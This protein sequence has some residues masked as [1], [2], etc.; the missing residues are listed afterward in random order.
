MYLVLRPPWGGHASATLD[1][2]VVATATPDAPAKK[3]PNKQQR[4][5]RP[6]GT[7]ASPDDP[8]D[9]G[10]DAPPIVLSA[11]DRA[12]EWRGE[13]VTLPRQ[14]VDLGGGGEARALDDGEIGAV[15]SG[16]SKPVQDCVV[17]SATGA[18][19]GRAT[20]TIQMVVDGT[21]HVTHSRTQAPH[22]LFEKGLLACTKST[23][24]RMKFPA[25]GAPTQ[26]TFPINLN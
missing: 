9:D 1:A 17:A 10:G 22:Y 19:L 12:L 24:A 4:R 23:V 6:P 25:T 26:V 2:G 13:D 16:Q 3:K 5:P 20:I 7:P 8:N 15:V 18:D 11:A 14:K 21:G